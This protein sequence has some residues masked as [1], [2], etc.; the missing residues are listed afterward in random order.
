M[1]HFDF[2][3]VLLVELAAWHQ[4]EVLKFPAQTKF[5]KVRLARLDSH[6]AAS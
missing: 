5:G 2:S 3:F 6:T 4:G 1:Q